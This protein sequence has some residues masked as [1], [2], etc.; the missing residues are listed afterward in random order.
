MAATSQEHESETLC[1][2]TLI[3][4]VQNGDREKFANIV[5]T[6]Q[7]PIFRY[8]YRLLGNRQD[9]E[10]AVQDIFIKTY[11]SIHRYKP[12]ASFSSWLYRIAGNHCLNLLRRRRMHRLAMRILK[13]G[14]DAAGAEQ[15]FEERL[16]S[17][18]LAAALSKLSL[19]ERNLL[20]LRVFEQR[21]Y[22][23]MSGILGI[24]PNALHKRMEKIKSKVRETMTKEGFL[25][26][27]QES[28][29]I[30]KI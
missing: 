26:S 30:T 21:T 12:A 2:D 7:Q 1:I 9:A 10:D 25:C 3:V 16:Y 13:P 14:S 8:C 15:E 29:L 20:V 28:K 11:E 23:E 4:S 5:Q 27:V 18:P 6:F 17:Y 22:V 24:S 19:E